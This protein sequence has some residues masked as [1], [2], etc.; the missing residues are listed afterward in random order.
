MANDRQYELEDLVNRPGTYFNPQTEVM[1]VV[2]DSPSLDTEIFQARNH[3]ADARGVALDPETDEPIDEE[4]E[5]PPP[6]VVEEPS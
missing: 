2:D 3:G 6:P 5:E 1:V 4:E